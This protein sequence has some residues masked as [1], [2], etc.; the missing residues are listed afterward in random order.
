MKGKEIKEVVT[1][2]KETPEVQAESIPVKEPRRKKK[3]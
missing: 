1:E 3:E 2:T